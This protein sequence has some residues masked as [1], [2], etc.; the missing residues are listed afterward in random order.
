MQKI[1]SMFQVKVAQFLIRLE[2][3]GPT[4]PYSLLLDAGGYPCDFQIFK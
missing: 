1:K 4:L 2:I 3:G